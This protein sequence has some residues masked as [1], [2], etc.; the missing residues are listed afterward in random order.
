MHGPLC[1][2]DL[3]SEYLRQTPGSIGAHCECRAHRLE[4]E[5]QEIGGFERDRREGL[6]AR[7]GGSAGGRRGEPLFAERVPG[8][9]ESKE[10]ALTLETASFQ[11]KAAPTH[12]VQGLGGAALR[13]QNL[14][15]RDRGFHGAG[16]EML[17]PIQGEGSEE[18]DRRE[19]ESSGRSHV[20]TVARG[21]DSLWAGVAY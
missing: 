18:R 21:S 20:A 13:Q 19:L 1:P 15:C 7:A 6:R 4:G 9:N 17:E 11:S 3:H 14:T 12:D 8:S 5:S 2:F 16:S 10:Q